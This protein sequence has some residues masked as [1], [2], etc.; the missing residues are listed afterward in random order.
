LPHV[1]T[2]P[3]VGQPRDEG[4][5]PHRP[6]AVQ[7]RRVVALLAAAPLA[8]CNRLYLGALEQLG[9]E[10]RTVLVNRVEDARDAQDAAK[11]QFVSALDNFRAVVEFDGGDLEELYDG[12]NASYE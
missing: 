7:R 1:G 10:K 12:L 4:Q 6:A 8:G 9:I 5:A 2:A 11:E 3:G